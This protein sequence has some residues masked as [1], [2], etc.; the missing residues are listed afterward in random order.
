MWLKVIFRQAE[1]W[2]PLCMSG[3]D[4]HKVGMSR[5]RVLFT[6]VPQLVDVPA[7]ALPFPPRAVTSVTQW[8][9]CAQQASQPRLCHPWTLVRHS[10][11]WDPAWPSTAP[12]CLWGFP[13]LPTSPCSDVPALPDASPRSAASS[14]MALGTCHF[15]VKSVWWFYSEF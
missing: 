4:D 13:L 7:M 9:P 5:C 8:G 14:E 11:S 6:A 15:T 3:Q 2:P 1:L 10:P 12:P